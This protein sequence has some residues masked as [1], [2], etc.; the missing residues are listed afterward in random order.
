MCTP[1][2]VKTLFLNSSSTKVCTVNQQFLK[3]FHYLILSF[4]P[5]P[6]YSYSCMFILYIVAKC[7]RVNDRICNKSMMALSW[8]K[9]ISY[10]D[11]V[12]AK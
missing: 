8:V 3:A 1:Q 11:R 2:W 9:I 5:I 4:T 10:E 6:F 12:V 7:M